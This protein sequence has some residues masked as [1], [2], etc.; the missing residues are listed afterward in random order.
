M[1][2]VT[3]PRGIALSKIRNYWKCFG[4]GRVLLGVKFCDGMDKAP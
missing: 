3:V 1:G 2:D 4:A